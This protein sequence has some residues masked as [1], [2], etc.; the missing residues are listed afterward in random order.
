MLLPGI[1]ERA[2]VAL[3]STAAVVQSA[4]RKSVFG[5]IPSAT[6]RVESAYIGAAVMLNIWM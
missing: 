5:I 1:P 6:A 2:Y 4:D 3:K